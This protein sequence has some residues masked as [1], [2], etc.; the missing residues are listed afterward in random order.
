MTMAELEALKLAVELAFPP[1]GG[2]RPAVVFRAHLVC[3]SVKPFWL[4]A[5]KS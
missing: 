1:S 5:R 4:R 3:A 2:G